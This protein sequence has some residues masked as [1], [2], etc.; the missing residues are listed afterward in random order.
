MNKSRTE[1]VVTGARGV[2]GSTV[3]ADDLRR[4]EPRIAFADEP[5][6]S[7]PTRFQSVARTYFLTL[8]IRT[9]NND[10]SM[11]DNKFNVMFD[12]GY[13]DITKRPY[14]FSAEK[15]SEALRASS[16][17]GIGKAFWDAD[18]FAAV[19][20]KNAL[21]SFVEQAKAMASTEDGRAALKAVLGDSFELPP[22]GE[23]A[24]E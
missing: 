13:V 20:K 1:T 2:S 24:Q 7:Y 9:Q 11:K 12:G 6:A 4:V 10:G 22:A 18:E 21:E 8:H 14:P 3:L 15:V 23:A 16:N 19:A 5:K 17:Y